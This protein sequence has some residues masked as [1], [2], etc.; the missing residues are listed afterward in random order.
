LSLILGRSSLRGFCLFIIKKDEST[1]GKR[2][3]S[4]TLSSVA[5][6][7]F[8]SELLYDNVDTNVFKYVILVAF[9]AVAQLGERLNG[10]QKVVGS[11][12]ISSTKYSLNGTGR[13]V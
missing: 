4:N 2:I 5:A 9:G 10:I 8:K 6:S 11:I 1:I 7:V 3:C 13:T 12:P